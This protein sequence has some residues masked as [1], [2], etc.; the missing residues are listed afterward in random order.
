MGRYNSVSTTTT[1]TGATTFYAPTSGLVT[2]LTGTAPYTVTLPNPVLYVGQSQSFYNAT[3]GTITLTTP[4]GVFNGLADGIGIGTA[5]ITIPASAFYTVSSD[6]TNYLL[7]NNSGGATKIASGIASS[8]TT[9]GSLV[10]TGGVGI[11]GDT[12][13]GGRIETSDATDATSGTSSSS[14]KTLGGIAAAKNIWSS[15]V[16]GT[17]G[18]GYIKVATGTTAQ[19]PASPAAG[20]VR[21]NTTNAYL[22]VHN[23]TSWT[24]AGGFRNVD[25]TSSVAVEAWQLLWIASPSAALTLTLP[26]SPNKGDTIR[27]VDVARNFATYNLTIARNGQPIQGDAANM[28]VATNGAAFDLIYYNATYGWRIFSI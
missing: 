7:N 1:T 16:I 9:S 11:S 28:T 19:Q 22:E 8:S 18:T 2:S 13:H 5:S 15:A 3:T 27:F 24:P 23:G 6:G 10:V 4:S 12:Y 14:I 21:F 25:I 26:A 17:T 20:W